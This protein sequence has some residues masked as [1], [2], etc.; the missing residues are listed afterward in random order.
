MYKLFFIQRNRINNLM[1]ENMLIFILCLE[2]KHVHCNN[3]LPKKGYSLS[4]C[5]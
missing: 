4:Q 5:V 3:G 1:K 2:T